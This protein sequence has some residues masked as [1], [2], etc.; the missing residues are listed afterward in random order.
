M[1][2]A[3]VRGFAERQKRF[4]LLGRVQSF[5]VNDGESSVEERYQEFR[6]GQIHETSL[7][8]RRFSF[9]F[10]S[11]EERNLPD[12]L[13]EVNDLMNNY[14]PETSERGRLQGLR[15]SLQQLSNG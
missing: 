1:R 5:L 13:E 3:Q 14:N 7:I 9:F 15:S 10:P 2:H 6:E 8:I 12:V 11:M 4:G